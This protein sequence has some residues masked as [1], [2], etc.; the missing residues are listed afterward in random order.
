MAPLLPLQPFLDVPRGVYVK[1]PLPVSMYSVRCLRIVLEGQGQVQEL[2][3]HNSLE[4]GR[5]KYSVAL[6]CLSEPK[7]NASALMLKCAAYGLFPIATDA[8]RSQ[9][10]LPDTPGVVLTTGN[11][12][13]ITKEAGN[14]S[15]LSV[16]QDLEVL[17][18]L[19]LGD[20][21]RS[22]LLEINSVILGLS[23]E[24][25]GAGNGLTNLA[26]S[27]GHTGGHIALAEGSGTVMISSQVPT[28][29]RVSVLSKAS[30]NLF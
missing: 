30:I 7:Y 19:S 28:M 27:N 20:A 21:T 13:D 23:L 22:N 4:S 18:S 14:M 15:S 26:L 24:G 3:L 6:D 11:L 12:A 29:Q 2:P 1:I 25:K 16:L 9:L 17:G 8:I 5:D 10:I